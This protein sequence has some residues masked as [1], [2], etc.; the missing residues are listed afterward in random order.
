MDA[1]SW[2]SMRP[3][4]AAAASGGLSSLVF[5]FAREVLRSDL[6]SVNP[7]V[8]LAPLLDRDWELD[9]WSLAIGVAVGLVLG[10]ILDCIFIL[11]QAWA[12]AL[13]RGLRNSKLGYRVLE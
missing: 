4:Q 1:V 3:I 11:R 12:G 8:C 7:E 5:S 10:P 13:Q 9:W 6:H 2:G